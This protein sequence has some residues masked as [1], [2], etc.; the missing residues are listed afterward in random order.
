MADEI[1]MVIFN[2]LQHILY[3][4]N[5]YTVCGSVG[6]AGNNK[7]FVVRDATT[8][9]IQGEILKKFWYFQVVIIPTKVF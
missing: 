5:C 8:S 9:K 4:Y 2:K 6:S 3:S 1:K 7:T